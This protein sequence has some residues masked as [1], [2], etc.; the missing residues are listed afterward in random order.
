MTITEAPPKNPDKVLAL[1]WLAANGIKELLPEKPWFI[2]EDDR[3]FYSAL[4]FIDDERSLDVTKLAFSYVDILRE[5]RAVPVVTPLTDEV[6]AAFRALRAA[7]PAD[8]VR[9]LEVRNRSCLKAD[10]EAFKAG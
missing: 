2:V 1:K 6:R 4:K 9:F 8:Q 3:I 10:A 5:D 7:D